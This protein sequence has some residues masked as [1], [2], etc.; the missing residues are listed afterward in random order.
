[1]RLTEQLGG[2]ID[3]TLD[4]GEHLGRYQGPATIHVPPDPANTEFAEIL[5]KGLTIEPYQPPPQPKE[6]P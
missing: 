6:V 4:E 2:A 1:M 5:E 3:V